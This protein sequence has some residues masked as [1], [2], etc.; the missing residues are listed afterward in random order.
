M[1]M[2]NEVSDLLSGLH[3]GRISLDEVARRFRERHWPRR[4]PREPSEMAAAELE[5]PD[6][7]VPGSYDDVAAA[8]HRGHLTDDQ[9]SVLIEAIA[10]SKRA[11]DQ[12][13]E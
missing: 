10:E 3:E 5:D 7:Y 1:R 11:E 13:K 4:Q 6:P 2:A 8:Y 12:A 9:Y